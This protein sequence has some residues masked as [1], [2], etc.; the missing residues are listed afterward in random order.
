[1]DR[2]THHFIH[3]GRRISVSNSTTRHHSLIPL[4]THQYVFPLYHPHSL[5][6]IIFWKIPAQGRSGHILL[7]SLSLGAGHASLTE[8]ISEAENTKM[9]RSMYAETTRQ[10]LEILESVRS[11]EWNAEMNPVE[12]SVR[13]GVSV[14]HDFSKG[15]V[16]PSGASCQI[17]TLLPSRPCRV[18]VTFTLRNHSLTNPVRFVL[19][20]T[21]NAT[22]YLSPV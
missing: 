15:Y 18:P 5:D 22:T 21:S 13:D 20:L 3:H 16:P 11:C 9:K 7:P 12:V 6:V 4:P 2:A 19:K 10:R 8:V 1:M 14:M 17:L